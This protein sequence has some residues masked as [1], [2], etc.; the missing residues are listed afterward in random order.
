LSEENRRSLMKYHWP[1]NVRELQNIIERALIMSDGTKL[2][3]SMLSINTKQDTTS[4]S[5]RILTATEFRY[6]EKQN[7]QRALYATN[8]KISGARRSS[9]I[10]AIAW[11]NAQFKIKSL[12]IIRNS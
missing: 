5:Q 10:T 8:W 7:I 11:H 6:L 12:G 4:D 9:R 1:G 3:F 2:D